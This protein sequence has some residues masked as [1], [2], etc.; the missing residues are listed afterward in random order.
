MGVPGR[1]KRQ[2]A[3]TDHSSVSCMSNDGGAMMP[4]H[5]EHTSSGGSGGVDYASRRG[6]RH[7]HSSSAQGGAGGSLDNYT[8][9]FL[10]QNTYCNSAEEGCMAHQCHHRRT[11]TLQAHTDRLDAGS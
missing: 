5:E 2:E 8:E 1:L 11:R 9:P 3:P 4:Q 7:A 6:M 10:R